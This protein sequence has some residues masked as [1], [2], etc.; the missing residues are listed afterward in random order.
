MAFLWSTGVL[1]GMLENCGCEMTGVR[2][3]ARYYLEVLLLVN[4][5][6]SQFIHIPRLDGEGVALAS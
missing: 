6:E 5:C 4:G 3:L 2:F 1:Q